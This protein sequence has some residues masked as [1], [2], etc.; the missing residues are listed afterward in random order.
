ME[1]TLLAVL[2]FVILISALLELLIRCPYIVAAIIFVA[3]LVVFAFLF[4]T[5]GLTF[6]IWI[7]AYTIVSF[8]T[9]LLIERFLRRNDR[10][11]RGNRRDE[12]RND[13]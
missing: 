7:I 10:D 4:D 8:L 1:L 3:S 13:F 9:A 11:K 12:E 5:L 2:F 6:I